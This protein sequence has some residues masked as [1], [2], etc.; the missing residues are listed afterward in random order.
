MSGQKI[1]VQELIVGV[2]L[3]GWL[4]VLG[5]GLLP[6]WIVTAAIIIPVYWQVYHTL[7]QDAPR[8]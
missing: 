6:S 2:W 3:T 7:K 5:F 8:L 4:L 1:T